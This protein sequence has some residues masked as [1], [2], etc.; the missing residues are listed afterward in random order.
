MVGLVV[1]FV[2]TVTVPEY[3][4]LAPMHVGAILTL[5]EILPLRGIEPDAGV[6]LSQ[7]H[8]ELDLTAN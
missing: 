3:E 7:P 8:E 6:A 5:T 2:V 1:A 4:P